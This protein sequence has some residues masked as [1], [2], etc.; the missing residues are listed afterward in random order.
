MTATVL[1]MPRKT[2]SIR[3]DAELARRAR[4]IAAAIGVSMPEYLEQK[5]KPIIDRDF[6]RTLKQLNQED[7]PEESDD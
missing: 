1:D 2:E 4:I 7:G 6:Q 3:L 5:L